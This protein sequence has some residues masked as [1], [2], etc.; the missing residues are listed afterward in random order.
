MIAIE[1]EA[2]KIRESPDKSRYYEASRN[3]TYIGCPIGS[4]EGPGP[5]MHHNENKIAFKKLTVNEQNT[6]AMRQT[7]VN[8]A[9]RFAISSKLAYKE[10]AK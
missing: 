9:D 4:G 2:L 5:A 6:I 8:V 7:V 3:R 1:K 10:Y